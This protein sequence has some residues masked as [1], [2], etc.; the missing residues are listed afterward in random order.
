MKIKHNFITEW[1]S[2]TLASWW[3]LYFAAIIVS[4]VKAEAIFI[5]HV[6]CECA[7]IRV[8]A[9]MCMCEEETGYQ[10]FIILFNILIINAYISLIYLLSIHIYML[11]LHNITHT[12]IYIFKCYYLV[13]KFWFCFHGR[14]IKSVK[15][16]EKLDYLE[17]IKICAF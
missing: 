3:Q 17:L 11:I 14:C 9:Y 6:P 7:C 10:N 12:H 15:C 8:H 16:E 1:K 13:I 4:P 2:C 5:Q